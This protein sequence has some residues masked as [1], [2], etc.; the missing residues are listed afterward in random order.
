VVFTDSLAE[1]ASRRDFTMN[2]IYY[3][4]L[5]DSFIDPT[6]GII[7]LQNNIIRFV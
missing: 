5:S 3:D 4:I 1:D 6:G 2:A 7:D